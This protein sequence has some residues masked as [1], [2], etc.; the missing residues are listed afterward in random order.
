MTGKCLFIFTRLSGIVAAMKPPVLRSVP[1]V[2]VVFALASAVAVGLG[3][4]VMA[5]SG[6][7]VS[8]WLRNPVAWVAGLGLGLLVWRF[9]LR[10][11]MVLLLALCLVGATYLFPGQN[12]VHR[13]I[14]LGPIQINAA[15]LCLPMVVAAFRHGRYNLLTYIV[16]ATLINAQPDA[17]QLAA[18]IIPYFMF[19]FSGDWKRTV[20]GIFGGNLVAATALIGID[21]LPPVAHVEGIVG[22]AASHSLPMT[23]GILAALGVAAL[24]PLLSP[25][26]A[27]DRTLARGLAVYFAVT[28]GFIATGYFPVPLAGYGISY[29]IGWWL[30]IGQ[31]SGAPHFE[32]SVAPPSQSRPISRL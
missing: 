25:A 15:A 9:P 7:P 3:A 17:S 32:R 14:G 22:L 20:T 27:T 18:F 30:G 19:L 10:P 1:I 31:L 16:L 23:V 26:S 5:T 12:H 4:W 6:L 28:I 13:W 8:L 2:M 21:R 29:V 24:S 11:P